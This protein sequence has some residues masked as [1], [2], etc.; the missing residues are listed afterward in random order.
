MST[1]STRIQN[2]AREV[3][4]WIDA[5]RQVAAEKR[6]QFPLTPSRAAGFQWLSL[7]SADA[8]IQNSVAAG[9]LTFT[10]QGQ[11]VYLGES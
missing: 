10:S 2:E 1:A 7:K 3:W 4:K 9:K 11:D 6:H 8:N 5:D